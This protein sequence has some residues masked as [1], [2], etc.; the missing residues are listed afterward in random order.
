MTD[1]LI[2]RRFST[3][4]QEHGTGDTLARQLERCEE[5][6][7]SQ[8]WNVVE[9]MT[10]RGRSA[11]KGE[12]L[13]TDADLGL[14]VA[15]VMAGEIARGTVLL[16]ERLDRLS[17]RPV[18]ETMAWIH[19]LTAAGIEI[20]LAD[21]AEVFRPGDMG[22][23]LS[24]AIRAALG[25][26]ESRK[27]S[28]LGQKAKAKLWTKA[29]NREGAWTNFAAK[30]P[31]WL[32]RN[33]TCDDWI[34]DEHRVSVVRQIYEMAADESLGSTAIAQRLNAAGIKPFAKP[35]RY[36]STLGTW[37]NSSVRQILMSPAVEGDWVGATGPYAG[38]TII[39]FYP[40]IVDADLVARARAAASQRKK[41]VGQRNGSTA[42]NLFSKAC[43]C[44]VCGR[45]AFSYSTQ[46]KGRQYGYVRC[47]AA[48]EGR[49]SNTGGYPYAAF[50]KTALDILIDLALDDRFFESKDELR[51]ARIRIAELEKAIRDKTDARTRLLM[52]FA[53][54]DNDPQVMAMI[55]MMKAEIDGLKS[56]LDET[57]KAA[58][59][60]SGQ[61]D[62]VEHLRRVNDIRDAAYSSDPTTRNHARSKLRQALDAIV[63][64][65]DIERDPDGEK[66]FTVIL[67]GGAMAF[68]IDTKGV[69]KRA[70][71]DGLG[72]PLYTHLPP[73]QREQI[74]PL[75]RRIE[76][77][78]A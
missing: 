20:A 38:Q 29:Q 40:R 78:A 28:D 30:I 60:A 53:D 34:E 71:S 55:S 77:L 58:A 32:R 2:Y 19:S 43:R 23:F 35:T 48:G 31:S 52:A 22:S 42:S 18:D 56:E 27:K 26:E 51:I 9:V 76:A 36:R 54:G 47:E 12:H 67:A 68:R 64:S 73:D 24:T 15:R 16:A 46:K 25:H 1:C 57:R 21:T 39:G 14:F 62:G 66:I 41:V 72:R 33:E 50:E 45:R 70:I 8:G 13:Q 63:M 11:F 6:A 37:G 44:G 75:I 10:D 65:V 3:D 7:V 74:A 4:E 5:F 59:K 49:C 61:V 69:F 17:R